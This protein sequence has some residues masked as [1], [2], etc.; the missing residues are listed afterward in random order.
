M[1]IFW[2]DVLA[3]AMP[4]ADA[5]FKFGNKLEKGPPLDNKFSYL[6]SC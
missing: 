5:N 1:I 3:E 2:D 4:H 6:S